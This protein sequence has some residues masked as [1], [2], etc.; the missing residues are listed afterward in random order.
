MP[1]PTNE[2]N[3]SGRTQT[4]AEA[5]GPSPSSA[6]G[7]AEYRSPSK[8]APSLACVVMMSRQNVQPH[9]SIT[10][11]SV[12]CCRSPRG[13]IDGCV[14][15][16]PST[17]LELIQKERSGRVIDDSNENRYTYHL[18]G[19]VV[20]WVFRRRPEDFVRNVKVPRLYFVGGEQC[21]HHRV[22]VA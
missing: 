11:Q 2:R 13:P 14:G 7:A 18:R 22:E 5:A 19:K 15:A 12:A 6:A 1:W 16:P 9:V 20:G 10:W 21:L 3:E 17:F 8:P 4:S